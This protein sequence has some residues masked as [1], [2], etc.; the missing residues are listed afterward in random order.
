MLKRMNEI[1]EREGMREEVKEEIIRVMNEGMLEVCNEMSREVIGR[2]MRGEVKKGVKVEGVK[3]GEEGVGRYKSR[4]AE[5]YALEHGISLEEFESKNV[6]K[7]EVEELVRKKAREKKE[8]KNENRVDKG[9][10]ED[11][12]ENTVDKSKKVEEKKNKERVIC[13]GINKRGES[14]KCTGTIKPDGARRKYCFRHSEDW[15]SFECES[16]SS[17]SESESNNEIKN[18]SENESESEKESKNDSKKKKEMESE[19][20][21]EEELFE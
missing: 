11:K 1:V 7:K 8:G 19:S 5:E 14:C 16:D 18:E 12:K 21:L 2:V 6:S 3:V 15:R 20:E 13:S 10:N 9:K 17:E 4:K